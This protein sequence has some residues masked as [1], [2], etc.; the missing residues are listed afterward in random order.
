MFPP[1]LFGMETTARANNMYRRSTPVISRHQ[2]EHAE[3]PLCQKSRYDQETRQE[4]TAT[5]SAPKEHQQVNRHGDP[6]ESPLQPLQAR[7]AQARPVESSMRIL[8]FGL[9]VLFNLFVLL[10]LSLAKI[11]PLRIPGS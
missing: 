8:S 4:A 10:I 5:T 9:R 7:E 11:L 6:R 1:S 2:D 3:C